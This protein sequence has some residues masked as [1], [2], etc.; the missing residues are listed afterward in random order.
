[1]EEDADTYAAL[2]N[3][4]DSLWTQEQRP[5]IQELKM[6]QVKQPYPL[7]MTAKR[8]LPDQDFTALLR[9]CSVISFRYNVI[10]G[11]ATNEQ[12]RLYTD[13]AAKLAGG[14][15]QTLGEIGREL[16][17]VYPSDEQFRAA[18]SEKQL[19]TTSARNRRIARYLLLRIERH[20]GGGAF[21]PASE[22][23]TIEHIL[24]ENPSEGWT[25]FTDEEVERSA[26]RLGN[27]ADARR[28]YEPRAGKPRLCGESTRVSR[29]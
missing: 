14:L 10:G 3:P 5:A 13:T 11:L 25:D 4:E 17:S 22:R 27:F 16:R 9:F 7:L 20:L 26:Y 29:E 23:Y 15:I 2:P 6:F 1:M 18:F 12:E 24:P 21:D 19:R 28:K 8:M